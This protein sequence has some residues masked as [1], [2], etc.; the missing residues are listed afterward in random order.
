MPETLTT[1]F[2]SG[3][4]AETIAKHLDALADEQRLIEVRE[5]PGS[6]QSKLYDFVGQKKKTEIE[7]FIPFADKTVTY[8]GKNS[9]PAFKFFSKK[10][11][12]PSK[13]GEVVG[14]NDQFWHFVS[15]PGYFV[16][17]DD[18]KLGEVVFD[19]TRL[20]TWRPDG[21]PEIKPNSG[22]IAGPAFGNMLDYNRWVSSNTVIGRAFKNGKNIA[23]Y[24]VTRV[25]NGA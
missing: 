19:Y 16:A 7:A 4:D 25:S 14:Y 18:N 17:Y 1:L 9:A 20:P 3:A 10:F 23:H 5:F 13:G 22:L 12:R 15:G 6:L 2:K 24:L 21:W 11:W 8:S